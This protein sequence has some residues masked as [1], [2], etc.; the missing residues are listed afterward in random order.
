MVGTKTE[1]ERLIADANKVK[2]ANGEMANLSIDSFA[3]VTEA[4]HIIQTEMDITGTT[5]K[6]ASITI[7]GSLNAMKASWENLIVGMADKNANIGQLINNLVESAV[8]FG[9][10]ML[11]VI[12]Q[13][14][15]G[16]G[17]L[18]EQLLPIIIQRIPTLINNIL[19]QLIKSGINMVNSIIQR[20]N[21]EF[22]SN[23]SRCNTDS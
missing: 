8:T 16:I 3:D 13:T 23:N 10:N 11:P 12:E 14:L 4:I 2:Q 18:I 15:L 9:Q 5:A 19:P 22:T 1:M 20:Y 6:E 21:T 17:T 7:E